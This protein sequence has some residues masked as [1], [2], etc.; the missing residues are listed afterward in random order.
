MTTIDDRRTPRDPCPHPGS[1]CRLPAARHACPPA[2]H[3]QRFG[4]QPDR[5][6][7]LVRVLR[8]FAVLRQGFLSE[9]QSD[10]AVA[11]HSRHLCGGLCDAAHRWLAGGA[12]CGPQGA[13]GG[14]AGVGAGHVRGL[15][16]HWPHA[17][18]RHHRR[19]GTRAA[20]AGA[21]AAGLEPGRRIR[22]LGYLP[23]RDGRR[24]QPRFLLQLPVRHAVA[25]AVAGDGRAGG[26]AAVLPDYRPTGRLGLAHPLPDRLAGSRGGHLP[27][28]HDGGDRIV[29]AASA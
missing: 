2:L 27:A 24:A 5:V 7:R 19:G 3:L 18:L 16:H 26:T 13:Q 4:R 8:L 28:P 9:R 23:E 11:E 10:G 20:G 22:Q 14:A 12:V 25:W 29:R 15:A 6:L 17:G 1:R 21:S